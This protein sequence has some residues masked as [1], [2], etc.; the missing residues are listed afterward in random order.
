MGTGLTGDTTSR[1]TT[2]QGRAP[3]L[4]YLPL[5][6]AR[7][8]DGGCAADRV[9]IGAGVGV[10]ER[11]RRVAEGRIGGHWSSNLDSPISIARGD[12]VRWEDPLGLSLLRQ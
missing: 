4:G 3:L 11:R 2:G 6:R 12:E 9:R 10:E 8:R 5:Y 1:D 7:V